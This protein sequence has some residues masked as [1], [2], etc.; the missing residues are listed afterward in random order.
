MI[1]GSKARAVDIGSSASKMRSLLL[2]P[3]I[4]AGAAAAVAVEMRQAASQTASVNLAATRGKPEHLA[5]GFI[6]GIPDNYP[7][8]I[9]LQ[10]LAQLPFS[11]LPLHRHASLSLTR[12]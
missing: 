12:L 3:L 11:C 6:Y 2:A 1:E 4:T 9:P 7:N 5:S 10:W 8:Q